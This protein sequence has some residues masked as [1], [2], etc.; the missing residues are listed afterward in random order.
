MAEQMFLASTTFDADGETVDWEFSFAGVSPDVQSGTTPYID[1]S[2]VRAEE[3]YLT[4]EGDEVRLPR[5]VE[6][7]GANVAR[8]SPAVAAG[9]NLRI[10]RVTENRFPLVNYKGLQSVSASDLDL[11][12]RQAIFIVQEARDSARGAGNIEADSLAAALGAA[13][14]AASSAAAAS[15]SAQEA[16]FSVSQVDPLFPSKLAADSGSTLVGHQSGTVASAL[17]TLLSEVQALQQDLAQLSDS[18]PANKVSF[19]GFTASLVTE[20]A[21][22]LMQ[23]WR[24][25]KDGLFTTPAELGHRAGLLT[26]RLKPGGQAEL[27]TSLRRFMPAGAEAQPGQEGALGLKAYYVRPTGSNVAAGTSWGTALA[28]VEIALTKS[29][30][31]IVFVASG[32][33]TATNHLGVYSGNRD[34]AIIAVGGPVTFIDTIAAYTTLSWG[35]TGRP[36]VFSAQLPAGSRSTPSGAVSIGVRDRLG[37]PVVLPYLGND[38]A[39]LANTV[40][41]VLLPSGDSNRMY[42]RLPDGSQP[43]TG[44]I[45]PFYT[46]VMRVQA[47]GVKFYQKGI[48]YVGGVGGAFSA[49]QGSASTVV[50]SDDC[51]FIGQPTGDNYQIQDVGLAIARRCIGAGDVGNDHFNYHANN[52][53]SPHFIEVDCV[54]ERAFAKATSNGSTSHES[55]VGFRIG[56]DYRDNSGPGVADVNDARTY[57]VG[58]SSNNNGPTSTAGGFTCQADTSTAEGAIMWLHRCSA[59]GNPGG[60]LRTRM[61]GRI[62]V[63]DCQVLTADGTNISTF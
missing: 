44:S 7:R 58:V 2:D 50:F 31:D 25:G 55:C 15:V 29:D 33:Y 32:I 12:N 18:F 1:P 13:L 9:R 57:N 19:N 14:A 48:T 49:R 41:M 24:G 62:R 21:A 16:A 28:S 36:T 60:D 43:A 54:A 37:I 8:V 46:A 11:A 20:V 10:F 56:C 26:Y 47:P 45:L 39:V 59:G 6:L 38:T 40:G 53:L 30:V 51:I 27:V 35:T 3:V 5:V 52:G 17:A 34:I 22:A 61:D 42:V 23:L 63:R 4:E